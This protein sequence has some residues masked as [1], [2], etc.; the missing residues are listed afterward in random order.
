MTTSLCHLVPFDNENQWSNLWVVLIE[1][2]PHVAAAAF[3]RLEAEVVASR[4]VRAEG[5]DRVRLSR[6]RWRR[7]QKV[8]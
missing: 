5:R 8:M 6:A 3:D 7:L 4:E 2:D 1:R